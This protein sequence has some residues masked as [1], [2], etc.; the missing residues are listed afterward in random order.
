ME[1]NKEIKKGLFYDDKGNF[2]S[3][4]V[5]KVQSV[6]LAGISFLTGIVVLIKDP[7][8]VAI[9][10]YCFKMTGLFLATATGAEI[11]QKVT[12]R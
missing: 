4:R 10:D 11:V 7:T 5:V 1:E 3:G 12:G 9:G 6:I 2:S 8:N